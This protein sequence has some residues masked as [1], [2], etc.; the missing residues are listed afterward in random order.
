MKNN[1][2]FSLVELIVVIAI[3]AILAAVAIPT[4]ASFI[5]K[6]NFATDKDFVD[7]AEYAIELAFAA[8]TSF[9]A[10]EV[11][12]TIDDGLATQIECGG[13]VIKAS[14]KG[15]TPGTIE[16]ETVTQE[17]IDAANAIDWS[18]KFKTEKNDGTYTVDEAAKKLVSA[19]N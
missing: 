8:D 14:Y 2:G 5:N 3:M 1:K 6:A 16:S 4:F 15:K 13:K 9:A 12:V 7:Q 11:K 10:T 17:Q 18:Y 19:T